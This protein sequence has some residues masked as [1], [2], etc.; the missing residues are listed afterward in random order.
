[1]LVFFE[2]FFFVMGLP[3]LAKTRA[4]V[5]PMKPKN[6]AAGEHSGRAPAAVGAAC[7]RTV[8]IFLQYMKR[9]AIPLCTTSPLFSTPLA[10]SQP[11][12]AA[13]KQN[14]TTTVVV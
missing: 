5:M 6:G 7:N 12:K 9:Y 8:N 4:A 2:R 10:R 3:K 1:M 14:Q 13:A 11:F